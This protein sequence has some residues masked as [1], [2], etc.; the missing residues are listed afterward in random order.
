MN[1]ELIDRRFSQI[2]GKISNLRYNLRGQSSKDEFNKNI[3][4]MEELV[5]D[6][7]SQ[8]ERTLTPLRNG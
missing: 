6:L 3:D 8:I 2:E 1:K 4:D 7:K 5:N